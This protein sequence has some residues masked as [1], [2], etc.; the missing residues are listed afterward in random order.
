MWTEGRRE[1]ATTIW[2]PVTGDDCDMGRIDPAAVAERDL[3]DR[4]AKL[5]E[6]SQKCQRNVIII[7]RAIAVTETRLT[8]AYTWLDAA[9]TSLDEASQWKKSLC[10]QLQLL[11]E[12]TNRGR[13]QRLQH[14]ANNY[15]F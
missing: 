4:L 10:D 9:T 3:K 13:S 12:D 5:G 15:L 11:V 2:S 14:V 8:E 1:E 6:E 7:N